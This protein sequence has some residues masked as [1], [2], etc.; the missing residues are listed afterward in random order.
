MDIHDEDYNVQTLSGILT[1]K[2]EDFV[3]N[4]HHITCDL[5]IKALDSDVTVAFNINRELEYDGTIVHVNPIGLVAKSFFN[6]NDFDLAIKDISLEILL[7]DAKIKSTSDVTKK[8]LRFRRLAQVYL[9]K[10]SKIADN[11]GLEIELDLER[12][13]RTYRKVHYSELTDSNGKFT[14]P[15]E[16]AR[17]L[18]KSTS[19]S[20]NNGSKN[21]VKVIR[22]NKYME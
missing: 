21:T 6:L 5:F 3:K 10:L 11:L 1:E 17:Y 20:G 4:Y 18:N 12:R 22:K 14:L 19:E 8:V 7:K 2:L 16:L 13:F 9:D 15:K